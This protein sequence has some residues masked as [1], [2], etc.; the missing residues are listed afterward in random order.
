[1][2]DVFAAAVQLQA[3]R[4]R[5]LH[6]LDASLQKLLVEFSA[7]I[8]ASPLPALLSIECLFGVFGLSQ[9]FSMQQNAP[10]CTDPGDVRFIELCS[11]GQA[12]PYAL[13]CGWRDNGQLG[14]ADLDAQSKTG[15]R[16]ASGA[17]TTADDS[18]EVADALVR[19][20]SVT[21]GPVFI[22]RNLHAVD[23]P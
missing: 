14:A 20:F 13:E 4:L 2:Q 15:F 11:Y 16:N 21:Q 3:A 1:M 7:A 10:L 22:P 9:P 17:W 12:R 18:I 8:V 5:A 6:L 19:A 23:L